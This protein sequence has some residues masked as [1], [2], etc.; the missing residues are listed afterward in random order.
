MNTAGWARRGESWRVGVCPGE[1][2]LG[3]ARPGMAVT[4]WRAV[5][6]KSRCG[7]ARHGSACLLAADK[8]REGAARLD[9]A[10]EGVARRSGLGL[11]DVARLGVVGRGPASWGLAV[12]SRQGRSRL[13]SAS[14][15]SS[16]H[17]EADV[18]R[19]GT[20]GPGEVRR[21]EGRPGEAAGARHGRH[22][23]GEPCS[24]QARQSSRGVVGQDADR[25]GLS[26]RGRGEAVRASRVMARRVM[27]EQGKAFLTI[28]PF[29]ETE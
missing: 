18:A 6:G 4:A 2:G 11:A 21:G 3:L 17:G 26:G 5:L 23:I 20:S 16:R 15:G 12:V 1:V 25:C 8:A 27:A 24:G 29:E 13:G 14:D 9:E 22:W 7:R 19:A 28:T 10:R